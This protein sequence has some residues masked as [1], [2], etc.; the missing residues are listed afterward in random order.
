MGK[1]VEENVV[2]FLLECG[3]IVTCCVYRTE[4]RYREQYRE[5]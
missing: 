4:S 3:G 1:I 5:M 2:Y